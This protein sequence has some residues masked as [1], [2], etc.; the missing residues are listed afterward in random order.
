MEDLVVLVPGFLGFA[1][2]GGFYYF[3]ERLIAVLRGSLEQ[4]EGGAMPVVPVTTLPTN[5]LALRQECLLNELHG[6]V[7]RLGSVRSI[8]L[9]GHSTGGV[10]AQLLACTRTTDD[11][12][13]PTHWDAIRHMIRSVITISAPH[14]GTQLADSR[15]ALVGKNPFTNPGVIFEEMRTVASLARIIPGYLA[16]RA[17]FNV[18]VPNDLFKFAWQVIQ[19]RDLIDDLA[20]ARMEERRRALVHDPAVRLVCFVTGTEPRTDR[21]RPSD[22]LFADLY[23]LT[24]HSGTV[25]PTVQR[26]ARFLEK[27]VAAHPQIV[28][29]NKATVMPVI[30]PALNDGV[31]NTARQIVHETPAELGG[32]VVADHADSLGHYDRQDGLIDGTPYDAGLFHSGAAFEDPQFYQ[33]YWRIAEVILGARDR[34]RHARRTGNG[35]KPED[36]ARIGS[37]ADSAPPAGGGGTAQWLR[38]LLRGVGTAS[39]FQTKPSGRAKTRVRRRPTRRK[40]TATAATSTLDRVTRRPVRGAQ[41]ATVRLAP[42]PTL[43]EARRRAATLDEQKGVR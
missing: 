36:G 33:M 26:C 1:R 4:P 14:H 19:N 41:R 38:T 17:G 40:T 25:S 3:A 11:R 8:H 27:Y 5:S 16:A 32:F 6:V 2:F 31:V 22:P 43:A 34:T 42:A 15:L 23:A 29:R 28:I 35:R 39:I 9:I 30:S 7:T 21:V 24:A 37:K 18:V 12:P 10:D 20:P 13:W